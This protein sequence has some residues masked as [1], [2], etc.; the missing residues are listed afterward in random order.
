MIPIKISIPPGIPKYFNGCVI[1]ICLTTDATTSFVCYIGF[2]VEVLDP[3][4]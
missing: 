3:V 1:A 2:F 4:L